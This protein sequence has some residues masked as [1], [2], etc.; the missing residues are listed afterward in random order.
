MSIYVRQKRSQS[1]KLRKFGLKEEG[2][3]ES[4]SSDLTSDIKHQKSEN[5]SFFY[6][7]QAATEAEKG[8][9]KRFYKEKSYI[10]ENL[11]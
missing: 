10:P 7:K 1:K 4:E 2:S 3:E 9:N 6:L 8:L 5:F 11:D